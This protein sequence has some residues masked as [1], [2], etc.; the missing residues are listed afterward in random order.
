MTPRILPTAM[1]KTEKLRGA[2]ERLHDCRAIF[3][4]AVKVRETFQ[5]ET[6]WEGSPALR[7][8][9]ASLRAP[10]AAPRLRAPHSR[11]DELPPIHPLEC[12]M[13]CQKCD[14]PRGKNH[15]EATMTKP[16][17]RGATRGEEGRIS[18]S[19]SGAKTPEGPSEPQEAGPISGSPFRMSDTASYR[20]SSR[21]RL[22]YRA[23]WA[24]GPERARE[25]V[26]FAERGWI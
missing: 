22:R 10:G 6:A 9:D 21:P 11:R 25:H 26:S 3:R 19:G 18:F 23:L 7:L 16:H 4:E 14:S 24:L 2:V 20:T 5:N 17:A 1:G 8:H 12:N 13:T 15:A